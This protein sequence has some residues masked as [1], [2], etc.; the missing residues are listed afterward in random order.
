MA[1]LFP[2]LFTLVGGVV[3][4][5][6]VGDLFA[7]KASQDWPTVRG[8]IISSSV[9]RQDDRGSSDRDSTTYHAQIIYEFWVDEMKFTGDRVA[10]GEF[11]SSD[12]AHARRIVSRYP[13]GESVAV[14]YSEADPTECLLEPGIK[15]QAWFLPG[16]GLLF[17][18][19]GIFLVVYIPRVI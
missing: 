19:V 16:V 8:V 6:G 7:A 18:I 15:A 1:R 5:L 17:F 10:F 12:P 13:N 11:G 4:Y 9:E 2:L 3:A 14:Y